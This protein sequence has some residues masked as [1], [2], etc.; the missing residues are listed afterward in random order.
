[1]SFDTSDLFRLVYRSRSALEGRPEEVQQAVDDIVAASHRRNTD[2]QITGALMFTHSMFVQALEGPARAVEAAFDRI[3]C[4]LRHNNL[5][6]VECS[7]IL[8]R[9]FG[10]WSMRHLP[11]DASSRELLERSDDATVISDTAIASM[12]LMAFLSRPCRPQ[13]GGRAVERMPPFGLG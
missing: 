6:V 13:L 10:S 2:A 7:P 1:M 9:G 11:P 4:D 8:E 3:C 12:K 5:E